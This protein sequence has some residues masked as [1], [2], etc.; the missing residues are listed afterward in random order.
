MDSMCAMSKQDE[1]AVILQQELHSVDQMLLPI[2]CVMSKILLWRYLLDPSLFVWSISEVVPHDRLIIILISSYSP[3]TPFEVSVSIPLVLI[4]REV[5]ITL[6][7]HRVIVTNCIRCP[8]CLTVFAVHYKIS[9]SL[10][11]EI[12]RPSLWRSSSKISSPPN[13]VDETILMLFYD[14]ISIALESQLVLAARM[15]DAS[16]TS[17]DDYLLIPVVRI[18]LQIRYEM[19]SISSELICLYFFLSIALLEVYFVTVLVH[20]KAV[21]ASSV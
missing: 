18:L 13:V 11:D 2:I 7:D 16:I 21:V 14:E 5:A 6:K 20:C 4:N 10:H 9:I 17:L 8:H 1:I 15:V 12:F 3:A 19:I